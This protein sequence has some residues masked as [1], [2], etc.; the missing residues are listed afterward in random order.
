MLGL[1][2]ITSH[3]TTLSTYLNDTEYLHHLYFLKPTNLR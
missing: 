3:N 1:V 2:N